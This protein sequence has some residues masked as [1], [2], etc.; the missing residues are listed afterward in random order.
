MQEGKED[1]YKSHLKGERVQSLLTEISRSYTNKQERVNAINAYIQKSSYNAQFPMEE[2]EEEEEAEGDTFGE[3]ILQLLLSIFPDISPMWWF[4]IHLIFNFII[5]SISLSSLSDP[6]VKL[7]EKKPEHNKRFILG[8]IYCGSLILAI[9]ILVFV[10]IMLIH[11]TV[12]KFLMERIMQPSALCAAIYNTLDPEVVYLLWAVFQYIYWRSNII[13]TTVESTD[14]SFYVL[15]LFGHDDPDHSF[16]FLKN[17]Y[18]LITFSTILYIIFAARLLI[19]SI[20]SFIFELGFLMNAHDLLGKYLKK[21]GILRRFNIEWFM[22][23]A[24]KRESIKSLFGYEL[25]QDEKL[26]RQIE[27]NDF[28]K[29]FVQD[30]AELLLFK[31]LPRNC[32]CCKQVLRRNQKNAM[33]LLLP[34]IFEEK[35]IIRSET[36]TIKNWLACHYVVNTPPLLFLLN[37]S[38]AL[39]NKDTVKNGSEIF[40]K[41]IIMSLKT[42]SKEAEDGFVFTETHEGGNAPGGVPPY[43]SDNG[44]ENGENSKFDNHNLANDTSAPKF[45]NDATKIPRNEPYKNSR[46]EQ[47]PTNNVLPKKHAN[48]ENIFYEIDQEINKTDKQSDVDK[49]KTRE[50]ITRSKTKSK[51]RGK[52]GT[53]GGATGEVPMNIKNNNEENNESGN[54]LIKAKGKGR[55][56]TQTTEKG[57]RHINKK[58]EQNAEQTSSP[59]ESSNTNIKRPEKLTEAQKKERYTGNNK[60]NEEE[61]QTICNFL[62]FNHSEVKKEGASSKERLDDGTLQDMQQKKIAQEQ[63][64]I[65]LAKSGTINDI[66]DPTKNKNVNNGKYVASTGVK[67]TRFFFNELNKKKTIQAKEDEFDKEAQKL[68]STQGLHDKKVKQYTNFLLEIGDK[69]ESQKNTSINFT[70][71]LQ[72]DATEGMKK[73][74]EVLINPS[75]PTLEDEKTV[76]TFKNE[77]NIRSEELRAYGLLEN[78]DSMP[79]DIKDI[80]IEEVINKQYVKDESLQREINKDS[81]SSQNGYDSESARMENCTQTKVWVNTFNGKHTK[82]GN[83]IDSENNI[84][85]PNIISRDQMDIELVER[86]SRMGTAFEKSFVV[87][88]QKSEDN[89]FQSNVHGKR[90]N[91][92]ESISA[93][94]KDNVTANVNDVSNS[95][96]MYEKAGKKQS[97]LEKGMSQRRL[98]TRNSIYK[99]ALIYQSHLLNEEMCLLERSDAL[100]MKKVKDYRN[101]N[102]CLSCLCLKPSQNNRMNILKRDISLEIDDPFIANMRSSA[103]LSIQEDEFITKEMIQVFLKPDDAEEF[104]KEFDLSGHGKIDLTMFRNAIKR[105]ISCRKK[106]IKSLKGQ[107]SILKL[108]RRLMSML[109]S[110]LA[111][112][113][114]LFIFGVSADTIIVTG[115]AFIT[116]VTVILSYMYTSFIT[117]VIFI[118]FSN[119]YNIGDRIRI[120]GGEAMYIRKIKT[121]TTEFETTTGKIVICENAKLSTTK[122]FNESRSKNAYIDI[123][124]K[125]DINTP[126]IALKELRKSLQF[127]VDS[128]PSDFCKTKNLYY[129]YELQPGHFYE[130]SFWIKCVEGW[131]NWRKVF[132]LRTDIYDFV[133]LQLRL[134]N[135]S[136]RLPTQK[137][138]FTAPLSL[139]DNYNTNVSKYGKNMKGNDL[140]SQL[141]ENRNPIFSPTPK[142]KRSLP[143]TSSSSSLSDEDFAR[144]YPTYRRHRKYMDYK[145]CDNED[146]GV[147]DNFT[148][149]NGSKRDM[150]LNPEYDRYGSEYFPN[151]YYYDANEM[152]QFFN[153]EC[154]GVHRPSFFINHKKN[155]NHLEKERMVQQFQ[156]MQYLHQ[157]GRNNIENIH[158]YEINPYCSYGDASTPTPNHNMKKN[159]KNQYHPYSMNYE[160][161]S[162]FPVMLPLNHFNCRTEEMQDKNKKR[163]AENILNN[164]FPFIASKGNTSE[165]IGNREIGE[166]TKGEEADT[167]EKELA[168]KHI[169]ERRKRTEMNIHVDMDVINN[170][171]NEK[172]D[173]NITGTNSVQ[174]LKGLKGTIHKAIKNRNIQKAAKSKRK[175]KHNQDISNTNQE[176]NEEK[177]MFKNNDMNKKYSNLFFSQ[178]H[179]NMYTNRYQQNSG[180]DGYFSDEGNSSGYDSY[181]YIKHFSIL[182]FNKKWMEKQKDLGIIDR[183]NTII[184]KNK[185]QD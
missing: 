98:K 177:F 170:N 31:N 42:H 75:K 66:L 107:E 78:Y 80:T 46:T 130:V 172:K 158:N 111:T 103:Q 64:K 62:S 5:I 115:A 82:T 61:K 22:Y 59:K 74:G 179:A 84:E 34:P 157:M 67:E 86:K 108:V 32:V 151:T 10:I 93:D 33:K 97:V 26:I 174:L 30:K 109:M 160:N 127:L 9:N 21:Y 81:E 152:T 54:I 110:F 182:G 43:P 178:R 77:L 144:N 167:K 112:V 68:T 118:A 166:K 60:K 72:E 164:R 163:Y 146:I 23:V 154:D 56:G 105:A 116:A 120:D 126:L 11:A 1:G 102:K 133:I 137:I 8:A 121:Y 2:E 153:G 71:P 95:A 184:N 41:Q 19:L 87:G 141:K 131:G 183:N 161:Y 176:K 58:K 20:I 143:F 136:Y 139:I 92:R 69:E 90:N 129:G 45:D 14:W 171:E 37:N 50:V 12:Q 40:F 83:E 156:Q 44:E 128:R 52:K 117:S 18:W 13:Y 15:R 63:P 123:T 99:N 168:R 104:M 24:D 17:Q 25:Y 38:V 7:G 124:F 51:I 73:P 88:A 65:T 48:L 47:A 135:I 147:R 125:V 159:Y 6:N 148:P 181:E 53:S 85:I 96:A 91:T 122:I 100:N 28:S 114:I 145:N 27:T 49:H 55:D 79:V 134:L 142:H 113:I 180:D 4:G 150:F 106:F 155:R 36:S 169:T 140:M 70:S 3:R 16:V 35:N 173:N 165:I 39:I 119:P 175:H 101:R 89:V 94:G 57:K 162:A 185:K 138:G 29:K 132:E 149:I 76:I